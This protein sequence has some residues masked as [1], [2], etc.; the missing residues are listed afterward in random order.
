MEIGDILV[1]QGAGTELARHIAGSFSPIS[2]APV[3]HVG[4]YLGHGGVIEASPEAGVV[5]R[6]LV[7]WMRGRHFSAYRYPDLGELGKSRLQDLAKQSIGLPYNFWFREDHPG[8]YCSELV[9]DLYNQTLGRTFF[10]SIP[11][12]FASPGK[13]SYWEDYFRPSGFDIPHGQ[14][15]SHPASLVANPD[16]VRVYEFR[17]F[18][19]DQQCTN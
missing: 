8:Y 13:G 6:A 14:P 16:L 10:P 9:Q 18:E 3:H 4:L 19:N 11:M 2:G 17:S 5:V 7:D 12:V 1:V 15:G